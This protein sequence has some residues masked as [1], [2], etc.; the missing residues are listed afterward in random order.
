MRAALVAL[1][2]T[3]TAAF[4]AQS[5]G[6]TAAGPAVQPVP[7][8]FQ[9]FTAGIG[10]IWAVR[11]GHRYGELVRLDPNTLR[12][13]G[14]E[15]VGAAVDAVVTAAGSIWVANG[16]SSV[17]SHGYPED[18]SVWRIRPRDGRVVARIPI[19]DPTAL[20]VADSRIWA[21]GSATQTLYEIDPARNR[22]VGRV[23]L[24]GAQ[25]GALTG[26][27]VGL[28]AATTTYPAAGMVRSALVR[29]D[30]AVAA[31]RAD[32]TIPGQVRGLAVVARTLWFTAGTL[33]QPRSG[34]VRRLDAR[35][36][37]P[38]AP[39]IPLRSAHGLA[40]LAGSLWVASD[41]GLLS[42]LDPA[43]GRLLARFRIARYADAV[44]PLGQDLWVGDFNEQTIVRVR[45]G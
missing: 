28:W 19:P 4:T 11:Q 24:S 22:I 3:A 8:R 18:A 44:W 15:P 38:V 20:A 40:L 37:Q 29:T 43:T 32:A 16:V 2:V 35:T 36:L 21:F 27:G 33:G 26:N 12:V 10:A 39:S 6:R 23:R 30:P 17:R 25:I 7:V 45:P 41:D 34:R 1:A 5:S 14:I 13:R 31:V 42:R 9:A